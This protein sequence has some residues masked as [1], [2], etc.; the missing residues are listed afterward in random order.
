VA[1]FVTFERSYAKTISSFGTCSNNNHKKL[2]V[3][4]WATLLQQELSVLHLME[5]PLWCEYRLLFIWHDQMEENACNFII[6]ID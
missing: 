3:N 6:P 2:A 1:S 4:P 5:E